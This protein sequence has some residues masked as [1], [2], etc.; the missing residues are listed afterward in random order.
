MLK[1]TKSYKQVKEELKTLEEQY[2]TLS[3]SLIIEHLRKP[4]QKQLKKV[5]N[6]K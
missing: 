5:K 3:D 4:N 2:G 6:I 1:T